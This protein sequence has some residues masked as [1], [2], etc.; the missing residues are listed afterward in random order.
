MLLTAVIKI[1]DFESEFR[2]GIR[3]K[4]CDYSFTKPTNAKGELTGI[5]QGGTINLSVESMNSATLMRWMLSN[6]TMDGTITFSVTDDKDG[7]VK[8]FKTVKF[9]R[10]YL[11]HL[12]EA[13]ADGSL[14]MLTNLTLSC[15]SI[16][17]SDVKHENV[18][19]R[20]R[21]GM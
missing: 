7:T 21:G 17:I 5:P 13:F 4:S 18:W 2:E 8:K 20:A 10:A 11:T 6:R 16:E 15:K 3:V 14:D 1:N 19:T 9:E 12:H